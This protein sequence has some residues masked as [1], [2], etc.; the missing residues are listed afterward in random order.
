MHFASLKCEAM[1]S[2]HQAPL[3]F[4]LGMPHFGTGPF[5]LPFSALSHTILSMLE[6]GGRGE[7]MEAAP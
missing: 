6:E 3:T 5:Y 2:L 7:K 4:H 1:M